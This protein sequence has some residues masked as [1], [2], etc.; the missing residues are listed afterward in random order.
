M[1][2]LQITLTD[3][4]SQDSHRFGSH[5]KQAMLDILA[6]FSLDKKAVN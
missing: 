6:L 5:I 2:N 4:S 3:L 1:V